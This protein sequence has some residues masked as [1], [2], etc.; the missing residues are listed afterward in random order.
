MVL[1]FASVAIGGSSMG[2]NSM[3]EQKGKCCGRGL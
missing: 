3:N 1:V 2:N